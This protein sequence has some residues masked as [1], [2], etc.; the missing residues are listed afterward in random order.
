MPT[1]VQDEK[2]TRELTNYDNFRE[3]IEK[4]KAEFES[5]KEFAGYPLLPKSW[6]EWEKIYS[7]ASEEEKRLIMITITHSFIE[8][9]RHYWADLIALYGPERLHF[10]QF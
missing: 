4:I 8:C 7:S 9:L 1:Y 3:W 5:Q 6:L 10:P 2:G